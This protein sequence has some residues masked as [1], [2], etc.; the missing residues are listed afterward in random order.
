MNRR[1]RGRIVGAFA[2]ALA[3][4]VAVLIAGCDDDPVTAVPFGV[5]LTVVDPAGAPVPGLEA[6]L[7]VP[8]PGVFDWPAKPLTRIRFSLAVPCSARVVV[9][10]MEGRELEKPFDRLAATGFYEVAFGIPG[11]EPVIGTRLYRCALTAWDGT[12]ELYHEEILMTLYASIDFD[13]R[14]ILGVT[15]TDGRISFADRREFPFLYDVWP[16]PLID[17]NGDQN[18]TFACSDTVRIT[19]H[20]PTDGRRLTHEIV[21]GPGANRATLV[22]DPPVPFGGSPGPAGPVAGPGPVFQ[23]TA[24]ELPPI[25]FDL[26]QN[27]PNP[28]N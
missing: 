13:Q 10:D 9:Q 2:T 16:Q 23:A 28:F 18:G 24:G 26:L 8:I 7:E 27:V 6:R 19:L 25:E 1:N 22:W 21:I 11:D 20:D 4:C 3:I 14:P 12:T 17:E 5:D 15:D